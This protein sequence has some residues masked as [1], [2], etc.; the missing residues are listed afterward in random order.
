MRKILHVETAGTTTFYVTG[1]NMGTADTIQFWFGHIDA[2]DI[3]D[4]GARPLKARR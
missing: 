1:L 4:P 3:P 2:T